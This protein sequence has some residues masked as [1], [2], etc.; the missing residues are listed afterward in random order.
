MGSIVSGFM[1]S[2]VVLGT[3]SRARGSVKR[4][5][6]VDVV[7]NDFTLITPTDI[8]YEPSAP[9]A[10]V[11]SIMENKEWIFEN[12]ILVEREI[13]QIQK[14]VNTSISTKTYDEKQLF[15]SIMGL[16]TKK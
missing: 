6:G 10:I 2:V 8:V 13:E 14:L 12:G 4:Q 1:E 16:V 9:D 7:Q 5:N 11:T 15:N 3:A